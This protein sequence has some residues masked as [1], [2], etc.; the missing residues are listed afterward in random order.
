MTAALHAAVK[1]NGSAEI[2]VELATLEHPSWDEPIRVCNVAEEG[3][4][5]VSQGRSFIA[6]P[7]EVTLPGRDPQS[8][9]AGSGFRINNV[10]A[11]DGTDDPVVLAVLRG[12]PT[13][14]R[15]RF[16]TVRLSAPDVIEYRTTRQRL[17][18]LTYNETII[19][20]ALGMPS[21]ADRR[22]GYRATPDQY[23]F[24]RAG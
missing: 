16:E 23:R 22:A 15:V 8:P 18:G 2:P 13:W 11:Q 9:F 19:Q 21:F 17:T 10:V 5:L 1:G 7:F 14:A 3:Y 6:Y 4:T 20:G 12:L 24:L